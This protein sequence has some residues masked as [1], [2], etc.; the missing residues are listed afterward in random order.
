MLVMDVV[1]ATLDPYIISLRPPTSIIL[2]VFVD[3]FCPEWS[4]GRS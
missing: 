3:I 4:R 2:L 1:H